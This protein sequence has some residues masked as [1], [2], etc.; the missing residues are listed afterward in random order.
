MGALTPTGRQS[1]A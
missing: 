1:L